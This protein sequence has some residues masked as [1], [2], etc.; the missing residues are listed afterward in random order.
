MVESV[1]G[2]EKS[3]DDG[4]MSASDDKQPDGNETEH[5]SDNDGDDTCVDAKYDRLKSLGD[6]DHEVRTLF[7]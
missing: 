6:E 4:N 1:S 2:S 7:C 3:S 5:N